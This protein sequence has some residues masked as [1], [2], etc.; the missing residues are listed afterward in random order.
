MQPLLLL[1]DFA[2]DLVGGLLS[3]LLAPEEDHC[4]VAEV[5][6]LDPRVY[7]SRLLSRQS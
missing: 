3:R 1:L 5:L 4:S 2:L 6:T 7:A